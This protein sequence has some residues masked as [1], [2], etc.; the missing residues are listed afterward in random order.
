[1]RGSEDA[2]RALKLGYVTVGDFVHWY[3]NWVVVVVHQT[4]ADTTLAYQDMN[5]QVV[6]FSARDEELGP[7]KPR[8]F[9]VLGE[10]RGK[11]L[12]NLN[13]QYRKQANHSYLRSGLLKNDPHR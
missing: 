9:R 6:V 10:F 11:R 13:G 4:A 3:R 8:E 7:R 5:V 2:I 1:M 12:Q